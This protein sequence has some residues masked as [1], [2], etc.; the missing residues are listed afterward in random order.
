MT[1]PLF[2][3]SIQTQSDHFLILLL[4]DQMIGSHKIWIGHSSIHYKSCF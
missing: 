3:A 1:D 4:L 2:L